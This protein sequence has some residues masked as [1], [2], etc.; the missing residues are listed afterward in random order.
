MKLLCFN[1]YQ[2]SVLKGDAMVDVLSVVREIPHTRPGNLIS[3]LIE[4]F[5]ERR[6]A[7]APARAG[8][9]GRAVD[10]TG[11][12]FLRRVPRLAPGP[13]GVFDG[14]SFHI[15]KGRRP[16]RLPTGQSPP[17][18]ARSVWRGPDR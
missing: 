12:S 10:L 7:C 6:G 2:L 9:R 13:L 14:V 8:S 5:S 15:P 11:R 16:L 18:R 1:D 3:G 4:R 17:G